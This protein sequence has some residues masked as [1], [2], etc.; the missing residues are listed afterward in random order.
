MEE[1]AIG[2]D[3]CDLAVSGDH[4][5]LAT[6]GGVADVDVVLH[7][8]DGDIFASSNCEVL[9]LSV[10]LGGRLVFSEEL[11]LKVS[12]EFFNSVD[13]AT[14]KDED[15]ALGELGG[16]RFLQFEEGVVSKGQDGAVLDEELAVLLEDSEL[17][18][19]EEGGLGQQNVVLEAVSNGDEALVSG[20]LEAL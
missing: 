13:N 17:S 14:S 12:S 3:V 4:G 18:A 16:G 10:C 5:V 8:S 7:S 6:E 9:S 2:G 15:G 20:S 1:G 11:E 19:A